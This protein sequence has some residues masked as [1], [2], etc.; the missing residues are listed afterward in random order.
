MDEDYKKVRSRFWEKKKFL[1][2]WQLIG[3]LFIMYAFLGL[4]N[5]KTCKDIL[6]LI[7]Q[8]KNAAKIVCTHTPTV[9][10]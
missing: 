4:E 10:S 9:I 6:Q 7:R 5:K 1:L 2:D 3:R 8:N